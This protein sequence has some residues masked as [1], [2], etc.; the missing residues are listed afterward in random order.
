MKHN[1]LK[2]QELLSHQT[3]LLQQPAVKYFS[4]NELNLI[5]PRLWSF[6]RHFPYTKVICYSIVEEYIAGG[7][8]AGDHRCQ[9][10]AIYITPEA[11]MPNRSLLWGVLYYRL[12][13][14]HGRVYS[15][16]GQKFLA[17]LRWDHTFGG[18]LEYLDPQ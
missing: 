14:Q 6:G 7:L 11:D 12:Y 15:G 17:L 10:L 5:I 13:F 9:G 18:A 3:L 16:H 8:Q 2:F 4:C 1:I